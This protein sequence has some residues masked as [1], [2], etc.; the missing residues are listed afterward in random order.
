MNTYTLQAD[1]DGPKYIVIN[2]ARA[3]GTPCRG[4]AT[5]FGQAPVQMDVL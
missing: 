1:E 4:I 3:S 5:T 2:G